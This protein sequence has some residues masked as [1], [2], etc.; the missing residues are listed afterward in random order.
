MPNSVPNPKKSE[1]RY[2]RFHFLSIVFC[3]WFST[4]IY[5][6]TFG[7]YLN[8]LDIG[9]YA[10]GVIMGSY[11]IMQILIR[12]PI[13]I[14]ADKYK[15]SARLLVFIGF[16]ASFI[17]AVL[18]ALTGD[19]MTIFFGRFLAGVTAAMWVVLTIWYSSSFD[20]KES[21]KAMGQ[22]QSTTVG[23][24]LIGM[25]IS[26][27]IANHLGFESLFWIGA[28][29]ALAGLVLVFTISEQD[30]GKGLQKV[31]KNKK[32]IIRNVIREKKLWALSLLSLLAHAVLFSTIFGFSPLYFDELTGGSLNIVLI[33]VSF[34]LPHTLASSILTLKKGVFSGSF[35]MLAICFTVGT[36]CLLAAGVTDY[37]IAYCFLHAMLGFS[38]GLIFPVLLDQVYKI[39]HIPAPKTVM[40]F[41]QSIYSIGIVAG[42]MLAGYASKRAGVESVFIMAAVFLFIGVII[43]IIETKKQTK[44]TFA[45]ERDI[46]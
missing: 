10:S 13:G 45:L 40:G 23:S 21:L 11:G 1:N 16:L 43:S 22:L 8:L 26:G 18:L 15:I 29:F 38:L 46:S 20:G 9:Y 34:M 24:Q 28:L 6:P 37:W 3:F 30:S 17:S 4:F 27:W 25:S 32:N 36:I 44:N 19:F 41:Y 12:L 5:I 33:V 35:H 14:I 2:F 42:P 39:N 7:I 31:A